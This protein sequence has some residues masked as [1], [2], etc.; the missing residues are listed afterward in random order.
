MMEDEMIKGA[1]HIAVNTSDLNCSLAFYR[2]ALGLPVVEDIT[3]PTGVRLVMLELQ[4]GCTIELVARPEE[5]GAAPTGQNAGL[6]HIALQ[7]DDVDAAYAALQ[8]KGVEFTVLP[9]AGVGPMKR[10]AFC[11]GPDGEVIELVQL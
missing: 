11:K 4:P 10:L 3:L 7:V 1:A 6:A 8:V 2:E 9:Q 5:L